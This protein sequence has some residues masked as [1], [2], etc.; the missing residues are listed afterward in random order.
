MLIDANA[1][2]GPADGHHVLGQGCPT[3]KSTPFWRTFLQTFDLALPQTGPSHQGGLDT[4]ISPDGSRG[5]CLDYVAISSSLCDSC[6]FSQ[7]LDSF[8]L[9]N[10]QCDHTPVALQLRW[11]LSLCEPAD[12]SHGVALPHE[13]TKIKSS[14]IP[15]FLATLRPI[16]WSQDVETQTQSLNHA[17]LT[18]LHAHCPRPKRGPK[19]S[20]I[21]DEVW[22]HRR[23]K[24]HARR[25]LHRIR[26]R[27]L[28]EL[29]TL[30]F[31]TWRESHDR[32]DLVDFDFPA[33]SFNYM[34]SLACGTVKFYVK[35]KISADLLKRELRR[36]KHGHLADQ[37]QLLGASP[38]KE[39][40]LHPGCQVHPGCSSFVVVTNSSQ[41]TKIGQMHAQI[42]NS[43]EARK[44]I[45]DT[46][47][48][49]KSGEEEALEG[50]G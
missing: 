17:I 31:R 40:T 32:V 23:V 27:R 24:L 26:A 25:A 48:T 43:Q 42:L 36:A 12:R 7:L 45:A 11:T 22:Q 30:C 13:R 10:L 39:F 1:E 44:I 38:S 19:K 37:L 2:A 50:Q 14:S 33:L 35:Y 16:T 49:K 6:T 28:R 15:D 47:K 46:K 4:W 29:L 9:G 34:S 20:F 5:H 21:T 18:E 41:I 3:S 8:D